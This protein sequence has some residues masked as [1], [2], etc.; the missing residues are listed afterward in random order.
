MGEFGYIY[1]YMLVF[2]FCMGVVLGFVIGR[3]FSK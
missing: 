2:V 1:G 3:W